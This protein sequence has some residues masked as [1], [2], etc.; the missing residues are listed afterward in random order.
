MTNVLY[1][2]EFVKLTDVAVEIKWYYFPFAQSKVI[3]YDSV[4]KVLIK[5]MPNFLYEGTLIG[6]TPFSL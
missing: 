5:P 2:D 6:T 4:R 1:E 3:P